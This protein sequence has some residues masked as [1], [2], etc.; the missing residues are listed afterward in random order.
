M[1][2]IHIFFIYY[3]GDIM[4]LNEFIKVINGKSN[5][6]SEEVINNIKAFYNGEVRG[7]VDL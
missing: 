6:N 3:I 4:T 7:R 1:C 5:I 2:F